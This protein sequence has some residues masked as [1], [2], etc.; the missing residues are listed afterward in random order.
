MSYTPTSSLE[1]P[2]SSLCARVQGTTPQPDFTLP[3]RAQDPGHCPPNPDDLVELVRVHL[4]LPRRVS[5]Y[6]SRLLGA[7][8]HPQRSVLGLY[9]L[10]FLDGTEELVVYKKTNPTEVRELE[11]GGL[12]GPE[13]AVRGDRGA[14]SGPIAYL[15]DRGIMLWKYPADPYLPALTRDP[16]TGLDLTATELLGYHPGRRAVLRVG[17]IRELGGKRDVVLR[18]LPP[19]AARRVVT[20]RQLHIPPQAAPLLGADADRGLLFEPL[21]DKQP[22]DSSEAARERGGEALAS[23]HQSTGTQI[24]LSS[25]GSLCAKTLPWLLAFPSTESMVYGLVD[26]PPPE[27]STWIHGRF[28]PG[29]L[30]LDPIT[31]STLLMDLDRLGIGDASDDFG[32]WIAWELWENLAAD[33]N[34]IASSL[35]LGY[36]DAGGRRPEQ[37]VLMT[38]IA[39][40]LIWRS[41]LALRRLET[42]ALEKSVLAIDVARR[43]APP[44]TLFV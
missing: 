37:A 32:R 25:R 23:L 24:G 11:R 44:A 31:G 21:L 15:A 6:S 38:A 41:G 40:Q 9:R 1:Q 10:R 18:V 12:D 27:V 33:P 30:G 16:P 5:V 36:I 42:G 35:L 7:A 29:T 3:E 34:E 39:S 28:Q 13:G 19:A 20:A 14:P 22:F 2:S 4:G 8:W 26:P 17:P 43:I